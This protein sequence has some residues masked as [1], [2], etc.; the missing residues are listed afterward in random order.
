[1]L[2][3]LFPLMPLLLLVHVTSALALPKC[4]TNPNAYRHNC[5]GSLSLGNGIKYVGEFQD[6]KMHGHGTIAASGHKYVGGCSTGHSG[7][8]LGQTVSSHED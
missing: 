1:M 7:S 6:N 5:S 2:R 8:W 4:P 3:K